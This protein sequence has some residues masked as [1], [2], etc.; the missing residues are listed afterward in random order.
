[1]RHDD[2]E[3]NVFNTKFGQT[4]CLVMPM[5]TCNSPATFQS[6]MNAIFYGGIDELLCVYIDDLLVISKDEESHHL[7]SEILLQRLKEHK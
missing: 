5:G 6:L 3:N 1:M 7:H 4:E 2:I